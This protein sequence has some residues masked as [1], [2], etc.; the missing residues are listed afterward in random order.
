MQP[1]VS[2][3]L[4]SDLL[5]MPLI[6]QIQLKASGSELNDAD[7]KQLALL[8]REQHREKDVKKDERE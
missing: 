6:G 1:N 3:L 4:P 5:P 8:G 2:L 7:I